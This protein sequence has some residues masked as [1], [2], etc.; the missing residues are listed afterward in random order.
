M[1]QV[2]DAVFE[3]G[4]FTPLAAISLRERQRVKIAFVTSDEQALAEDL[5]TRGLALLAEN[6]PAYEFLADP[7]EDVYS[8]QDGEPIA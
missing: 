7:R 2:I 5:P 1:I 8:L 4:R 6:S 3:N